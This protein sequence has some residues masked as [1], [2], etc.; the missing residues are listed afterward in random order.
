MAQVL[1][2][3]KAAEQNWSYATAARAVF[4]SAALCGGKNRATLLRDMQGC[5]NEAPICTSIVITFWQRYLCHFAQTI[6]KRE[7]DLVLKW[8]PLF[9]DR[10]LPGD[11]T[12]SMKKCGWKCID[13]LNTSSL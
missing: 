6:G 8:M 13:K 4:K 3:M 5:W 9:A 11:L 10:G 7:L 1:V 12:A 2:E